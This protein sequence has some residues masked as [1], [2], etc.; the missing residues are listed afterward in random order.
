MIGAMRTVQPITHHRRLV[1]IVVVD[2]AIIDDSVPAGERRH[3]Q[4]MC[5]Y[6][7]EVA[8]G[9]LPGPYTDTAAERYA[10]TA[11]SSQ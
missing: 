7:L 3:V 1:A 5:L 10:H 2:H 11:L 9:T 8:N 4:A 6:A